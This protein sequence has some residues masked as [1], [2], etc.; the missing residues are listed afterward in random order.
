MSARRRKAEASRGRARLG[1]RGAALSV[2]LVALAAL[3]G[4]RWRLVRSLLARALGGAAARA[5]G[6]RAPPRAYLSGFR[7]EEELLRHPDAFTQG[8]CIDESGAL[9]ESVGHYGRSAVRQLVV[10]RPAA[11][12]GAAGARASLEVGASHALEPEL[13]GEGLAALPGHR[14]LQ[15]TWAEGV[16]LNFETRPKLRRARARTLR[17]EFRQSAQVG[18]GERS[19]PREMWGVA[20]LPAPAGSAGRDGGRRGDG[21]GG[22]DGGDVGGGGSLVLSNGTSHL[23]FLHP[24]SLRIQRS[25]RV[26]DPAL[27]SPPGARGDARGDA[28]RYAGGGYVEGLNELEI[29]A[30]EIWANVYPMYQRAHSECV[31]RIDPA[32]G[33]V[34]GWVDL[35]PL[36]AAQPT[37][38]AD[39]FNNVLNGIAYNGSESPDG[40]E[41]AAGAGAESGGRRHGSLYVTGKNWDRIYRIQLA[42]H[43]AAGGGSA[44]EGAAHVRRA[45]GLHLAA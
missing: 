23:L 30:G 3:L 9:W 2:G 26:R 4:A 14:L 28:G 11:D 31:A 32:D 38:L 8:L 29:V 24:D 12:G 40:P 22:G 10:R 5:A 45:C 35:A 17:G 18:E 6:P 15:L 1:A 33:R 43:A 37:F 25:V 27:A 41:A 42:P 44:A 13:F 39:S 34:L 16:V 21:V 7:V 20:Y 19:R 36:A